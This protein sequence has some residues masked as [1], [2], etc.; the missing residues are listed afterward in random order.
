MKT[1]EII[2]KKSLERTPL[3]TSRKYFKLYLPN[4][5]VIIQN[6][7]KQINLNFQIKVPDTIIHQVVSTTLLHRQPV[8]I[9]SE[10]LTTNSK[11]QEVILKLINKTSCFTF[12]FTKNTEI[13]TLYFFTEP[14]EKIDTVCKLEKKPKLE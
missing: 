4:D 10:L 6:Q 2:V 12:K 14:D 11:Y 8:E 9:C 3:K 5:F 1:V 7:Q 13:V